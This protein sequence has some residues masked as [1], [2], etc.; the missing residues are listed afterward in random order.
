M[1]HL[2]N[3]HSLLGLTNYELQNYKV[4]DHKFLNKKF[5]RSKNIKIDY[6]NLLRH[7]QIRKKN[8]NTLR[9][10]LNH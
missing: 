4:N 8:T 1:M 6:N 10:S 3:T 7:L 2:N 5:P 9:L